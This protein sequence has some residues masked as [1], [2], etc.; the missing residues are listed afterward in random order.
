MNDSKKFRAPL[1]RVRGLG[2]AKSG[3]EHWW[4]QRLTAVALI[5]L[6][7]VFAIF[8]IQLVGDTYQTAADF[9]GRPI[10]AAIGMLLVVALFWHLKLGGQVVIEDYVHNE[11]LK[12]ASVVLLTFV[13]IALGLACLLSL[14]R[15]VV[16]V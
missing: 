7:L 1:A 5:P 10:P 2:A 9:L 8:A 16:G 12:T 4:L 14:L 6:V 15:L 3:V 11:G 13:C